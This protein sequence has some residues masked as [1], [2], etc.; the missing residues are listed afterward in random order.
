MIDRAMAFAS[1]KHEGQT[2]YD[3][4]YISHCLLVYEI[5]SEIEP[6]NIEM[7][8]GAVLHDTLED[9]YTSVNELKKNFNNRIASLV[10]EL[11]DADYRKKELGHIEYHSKKMLNLSDDALTIKLADRISQSMNIY[12]A[13]KERVKKRAD[14]TSAIIKFLEANRAL[15]KSHKEL[16]TKFKQIYDTLN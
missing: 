16:I 9:T 15:N 2:L 1:K 14:V 5:V 13:P 7:Q 11:T 8:V 12:N 10:V 3:K 6:T 4:P